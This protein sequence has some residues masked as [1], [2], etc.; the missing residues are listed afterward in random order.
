MIF[1]KREKRK[2]KTIDSKEESIHPFIFK[3]QKINELTIKFEVIFT[4][5]NQTLATVVESK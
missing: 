4:L 2:Q 5:L 3:L 1:S